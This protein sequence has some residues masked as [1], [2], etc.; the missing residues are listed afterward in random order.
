MA[1]GHNTRN[2]DNLAQ[3]RGD[4]DVG[5]GLGIQAG[6][7]F[8][9]QQQI[10]RMQQDLAR[11]SREQH[12]Q[13]LRLVEAQLELA[14]EQA[15]LGAGGA[16][17]GGGGGV[18]GGARAPQF[19]VK[20]AINTLPQF[21]DRDID[22][23]LSNFEKI[24]TSQGWPGAQW[25]NILTPLLKG[26]KALRAFNRLTVAQLSDYKLLKRAL[27]AEFSLI[28]EVY[29]SRFRTSTKRSNDSYADFS[30]FL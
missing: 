12:Q 27:L 20:D 1:H 8:E 3:E 6:L 7:T 18:G 14:R 10:L 17:G 23:Y 9:Q 22:L 15:R 21:D 2:K 16:G 29:R 24:A 25:S 5:V 13:Q 11:E 30:Q 4:G 26:S 19:S 28:P